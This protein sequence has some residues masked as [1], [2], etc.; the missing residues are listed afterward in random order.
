MMIIIYQENQSRN[1]PYSIS[2][3]WTIYLAILTI[4]MIV[5]YRQLDEED[6]VNDHCDDGQIL[7]FQLATTTAYIE[8]IIYMKKMVKE[9]KRKK[10]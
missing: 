4:R 8:A 9:R 2:F 5:P 10:Q 1:I 6:E 3:S 7:H